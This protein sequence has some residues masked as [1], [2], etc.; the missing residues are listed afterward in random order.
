LESTNFGPV[1]YDPARPVIRDLS[2]SI[3]GSQ[4]VAITGPNGSGKTTLPALI[5]GQLAPQDGEVD[6]RVPFAM[7]DQHLSFLDSGAS[8]RANFLRLNPQADENE[9]RASLARFQFRADDAMIKVESLSGGQKSRAALACALGRSDPPALLILDEPTN[10]LDLN[11][12]E[13]LESALAA[14]DGSL[15][16]VSHDEAFLA[17][18]SLDR[19]IALTTR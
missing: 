16:V 17:R 6:L 2:L 8:I 4:R 7:L 3:I 5:T 11:S 13:A 14:Y 19:R 1:N 15:L 12:I 10:Y 18:L 9:C